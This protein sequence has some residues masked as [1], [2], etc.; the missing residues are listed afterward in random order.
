MI[1]NNVLS[2]LLNRATS[3]GC[4]GYHP[5]CQAVQLTHLSFERCVELTGLHINASKSSL[6]ASGTNLVGLYDELHGMKLMWALYPSG[7]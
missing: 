2:K 1:L 6:Y 4:F 7:I 5:Q 3:Y